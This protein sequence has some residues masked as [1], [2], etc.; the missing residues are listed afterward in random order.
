MKCFDIFDYN[1]LEACRR[2]R[3]LSKIMIDSL[4]SN[5]THFHNK[6]RKN[7]SYVDAFSEDFYLGIV[8]EPSLTVNLDAM[9][10]QLHAMLL[11]MAEELKLKETPNQPLTP[12]I[13]KITAAGKSSYADLICV[14]CAKP[15]LSKKPPRKFRIQCT[16]PPNSSKLY[17]NTSNFR[18]HMLSHVSKTSSISSGSESDA[19]NFASS[20][21]KSETTPIIIET[22]DQSSIEQTINISMKQCHLH[23]SGADAKIIF[24]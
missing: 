1:G 5:Q 3:K 18:K 9:K 17:W 12:D 4:D 14:Y 6:N 20:S 13:I 19:T 16:S 7:V 8:P 2:E 22:A 15:T 24:N 11:S 10:L 23:S 21:S